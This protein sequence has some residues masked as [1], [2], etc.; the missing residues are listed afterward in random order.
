[1]H[2]WHLIMFGFKLN[3]SITQKLLSSTFDRFLNDFPCCRLE[4]TIYNALY[5]FYLSKHFLLLGNGC[6]KKLLI[7]YVNDQKFITLRRRRRRKSVKSSNSTF[8]LQIAK[9]N[10]LFR[11]PKWLNGRTL[12]ICSLAINGRSLPLKPE[13]YVLGSPINLREGISF[14]L[15]SPTHRHR[16][17][18]YVEVLKLA[19]FG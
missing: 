18:I 19:Y 8:S 3:F 13:Y 4:T 7:W 11:D 15:N 14:N 10:K 6:S 12:A 17:E 16:P 5:W 9:S 1:M 2:Q